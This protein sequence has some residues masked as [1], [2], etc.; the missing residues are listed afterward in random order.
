MKI[1]YNV[2]INVN[3][4]WLQLLDVY[5]PGSSVN[6]SYR[7]QVMEICSRGPPDCPL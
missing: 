2:S 1:I 7:K 3:K 5:V 6:T 4:S